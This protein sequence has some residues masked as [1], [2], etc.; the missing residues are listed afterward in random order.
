MTKQNDFPVEANKTQ[1]NRLNE[2]EFN[3]RL[4]QN[5]NGQWRLQKG[6]EW[7]GIS[8]YYWVEYIDCG[9]SIFVL[10]KG[11]VRKDR[12]RLNL[13][14]CPFCNKSSPLKQI[15]GSVSIYQEWL[16]H[17]T[18]DKVIFLSKSIPRSANEKKDFQCVKCGAPFQASQNQVQ[19]QKHNGCTKCSDKSKKKPRAL[20][21]NIGVAER[22]GYEIL[23]EDTYSAK[24]VISLKSSNGE[25]IEIS[26]LDLCRELPLYADGFRKKQQ[27]NNLNHNWEHTNSGKPFTDEEKTWLYDNKNK[28]NYWQIAQHLGR[29]V[30]SIKQ[31]FRNND[32]L[33]NQRMNYGRLTSLDDNAFDIVTPES[34]YWAGFIAAKGASK[35]RAKGFKIDLVAED[36][37]H[38]GRLLKFLK[39]DNS[40]RY[41]ISKQT[42]GRNIY[43][44]VDITSSQ[45]YGKLESIYNLTAHKSLTLNPPNITDETCIAAYMLGFFDGDGHISYYSDDK[46]NV[47]IGCASYEFMEWY[48]TQIKNLI[49]KSNIEI[50]TKTKNVINPFY[51]ISLYTNEAKSFLNKLYSSVCVS[52]GRKKIKFLRKRSVKQ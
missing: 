3:Q 21:K 44:G 4:K 36:E 22:R 35:G 43:A 40:V 16:N 6:Q 34:A 51:H 39:A 33:N 9:H 11:V 29:S 10:A 12:N 17:I 1:T 14:K 52:L 19:K 15:N 23:C 25:V 20:L 28:L 5:S 24:E 48:V 47:Q 26:L 30:G 37:L 31:L 42:E 2:Q 41:R 18:G 8:H 45:I 46:F 32:W 7:L 13:R 50:Y 27:L 49:G 38:L